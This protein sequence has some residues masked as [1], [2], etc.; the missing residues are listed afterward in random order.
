MNYITQIDTDILLFFNGLHH[1]CMDNAM[2]VYTNRLTWIPFY[3]ALVVMTFIRMRHN[4]RAILLFVLCMAAAIT[5]SDQLC[6]HIIRN[7]IGRM[8]PSNPANPISVLLH[9]VN[10]Y[11]SGSFGFPSCHAANTMALASALHFV[12][13]NKWLNAVMAFWVATNCY[14]RLYLGVHY[15]GDLLAGAAAGFLVSFLVFGLIPWRKYATPLSR[16]DLYPPVSVMVLTMAVAPA[17]CS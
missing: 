14:T 6:G 5:V 9:I 17:I 13:R 11:R 3:M 4:P 7:A 8:R 16:Q 1:D 12:F 2:L 10:G 15:P